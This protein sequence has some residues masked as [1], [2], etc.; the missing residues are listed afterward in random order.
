MILLFIFLFQLSR[1]LK[2]AGSFF[3]I[4]QKEGKRLV[5]IILQPHKAIRWPG[6]LTGL[7]A[8]L[9]KILQK[10]CQTDVGGS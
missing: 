9:V 8:F 4:R 1:C 7:R 5:K 10:S 2:P 3:F 6:I